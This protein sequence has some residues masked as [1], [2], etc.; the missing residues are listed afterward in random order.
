MRNGQIVIKNEGAAPPYPL[1]F[2]EAHSSF[3]PSINAIFAIF[4]F[5]RNPID[6]PSYTESVKMSHHEQHLVSYKNE[7]FLKK[8]QSL[9]ELENGFKIT[10]PIPLISD[11]ELRLTTK[12]VN[13]YLH[14]FDKVRDEE[15]GLIEDNVAF[16][17]FCFN[18][19]VFIERHW[20]KLCKDLRLGKI[21]NMLPIS[22]ERRDQLEA[23]MLPNPKR[24][25]LFEEGLRKLG[26]HDRASGTKAT[27]K[28]VQDAEKDSKKFKKHVAERMKANE[29]PATSREHRLAMNMTVHAEDKSF[30]SGPVTQKERKKSYGASVKSKTLATV[31]AERQL[32]LGDAADAKFDESATYEN[33]A[34]PPD[35]EDATSMLSNVSSVDASYAGSNS[36]SKFSKKSRLPSSNE[37][38][39]SQFN[40]TDAMRKMTLRDYFT[41]SLE[42]DETTD[43]MVE[44]SFPRKLIR[45]ASESDLRPMTMQ[46]LF[47]TG[48]VLKKLPRPV[49]DDIIAQPQRTVKG[50]ICGHPGCGQGE[51]APRRIS[52]LFFICTMR[53]IA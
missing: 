4:Q 21:N 39:S 36:S 23:A 10:T 34:I 2:S 46:N 42:Y 8:E 28:S 50:F 3:P 25:K 45:R 12:A 14:I 11:G 32:R 9:S 22:K 18:F 38:L 17:N 37:S 16:V 27:L 6:A 51:N 30:A 15:L 35:E 48:Q 43:A 41:E 7:T 40:I 19:I 26:F 47:K 5:P 53:S 31:A 20:R 52:F 49:P 44:T 1:S 24:A 33:E 13:L 29:A